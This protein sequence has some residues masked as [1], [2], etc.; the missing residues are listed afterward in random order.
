MKA[1]TTFIMMFFCIICYSQRT[2]K[3]TDVMLFCG[4]DNLSVSDNW[5][6]RD[7]YNLNINRV[8]EKRYC[9]S[10]GQSLVIS[11]WT[12][13]NEKYNEGIFDAY[14]YLCEQN[15][16]LQVSIYYNSN[17][18]IMILKNKTKMHILSDLGI[19]RLFYCKNQDEG[20]TNVYP[21]GNTLFNKRGSKYDFVLIPPGETA[22]ASFYSWAK[23]P[24]F[25]LS[26]PYG[27]IIQYS[28]FNY[29]FSSNPWAIIIKM[30]PN[31][32]RN[33]R[34]LYFIKDR[35]CYFSLQKDIISCSSFG[36]N[37]PIGFEYRFHGILR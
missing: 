8:S 13:K 6:A 14:K 21:T 37:K 30:I 15:D 31:I 29:A 23:I 24:I 22:M 33:G 1:I 16:G 27:T 36:Y 25:S 32:D 19:V 26:L 17:E 35:T 4:D 10:F 18:L 5:S 11:Y 2:L 7:A 28:I 34:K 12:W 9:K 20:I 3:F